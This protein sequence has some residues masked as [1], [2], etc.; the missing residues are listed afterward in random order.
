MAGQNNESKE[1]PELSPAG[2]MEEELRWS[3]GR[4]W[5]E[6]CPSPNVVGGGATHGE[7]SREESPGRVAGKR[8]AARGRE[9]RTSPAAQQRGGAGWGNWLGAASGLGSGQ[10]DDG[11]GGGGCGEKLP[12]TRSDG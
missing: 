1:Q 11:V 3:M 12:E 6:T 9:R 8:L 4:S 7:W 2:H 10:E 5:E